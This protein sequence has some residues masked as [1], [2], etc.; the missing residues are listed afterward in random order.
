MLRPKNPKLT[1]KQT[2]G[3]RL[4]GCT[5]NLI[6]PERGDRS[7]RLA[8]IEE[9]TEPRSSGRVYVA[10]CAAHVGILLA[11]LIFGDKPPGQPLTSRLARYLPAADAQCARVGTLPVYA[12][13]ALML[14]I[15]IAD[16]TVDRLL[17]ASRGPVAAPRCARKEYVNDDVKYD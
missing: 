9:K 5:L 13:V 2:T 7:E 10:T 16:E 8:V 6:D 15:A 17:R 4:A 12:I 1:Q 3:G 11:F 14:A